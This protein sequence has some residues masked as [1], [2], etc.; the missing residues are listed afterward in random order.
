[1]LRL[2]AFALCSA[3]LIGCATQS[4]N[5]DNDSAQEPASEAKPAVSVPEKPFPADSLYD[6]LVAEFALRRQAVGT[7][8]NG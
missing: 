4:P 5:G 2:L 6:L 7:P 3:L 8:I 1:M